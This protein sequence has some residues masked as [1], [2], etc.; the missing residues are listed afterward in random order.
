MG[1]MPRARARARHKSI[2]TEA[3]KLTE[4][5]NDVLKDTKPLRLLDVL[6]RFYLLSVI[7]VFFPPLSLSTL[8]RDPCLAIVFRLCEI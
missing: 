1:V 2:E 5:S 3:E 4:E 8:E 7:L 6:L